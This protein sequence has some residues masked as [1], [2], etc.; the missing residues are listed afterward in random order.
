ML[1][2]LVR[3]NK[4]SLY[5]NFKRKISNVIYIKGLPFEVKD[6]DLSKVCEEYGPV[7]SVSLFPVANDAKQ[8]YGA[9]NFTSLSSAMAFYDELDRSILFG[10]RIS[11][12]F[13][14]NPTKNPLHKSSKYPMKDAS[15]YI[16]NDTET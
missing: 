8:S 15:H 12:Q 7:H 16:H 4:V 1:R 9:V 11:L 5:V 14:I 6:K 13:S 2:S 10:K 3:G